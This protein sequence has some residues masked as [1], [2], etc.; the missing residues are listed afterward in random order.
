MSTNELRQIEFE[1]S[2]LYVCPNGC[3]ES[4]LELGK[5]QQS[6]MA[7]MGK[8]Y[9]YIRCGQCGFGDSD[10]EKQAKVDMAEVIGVWNQKCLEHQ[11]AV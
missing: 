6:F 5:D 7:V 1:G 10:E 8:P 3:P 11:S 9:K 4:E 2:D